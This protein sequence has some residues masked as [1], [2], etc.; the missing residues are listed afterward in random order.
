MKL[1]VKYIVVNESVKTE[2]FDFFRTA[3]FYS[4]N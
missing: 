3:A 1:F 2:V 4:R